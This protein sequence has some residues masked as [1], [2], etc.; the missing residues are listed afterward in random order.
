MS[1]DKDTEE[2]EESEESEEVSNEII[3]TRKEDVILMSPMQSFSMTKK[4]TTKTTTH[5][6][7]AVLHA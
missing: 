3:D 7:E 2:S 6:S 1:Y 5:S 4:A